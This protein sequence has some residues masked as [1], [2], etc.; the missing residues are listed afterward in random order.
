MANPLPVLNRVLDECLRRVVTS[1][2]ERSPADWISR[3]ADLADLK[4]HI[5]VELCRRG[6]LLEREDRI[7]LLFRRTTYPTVDGEPERRVIERIEAA[8][9]GDPRDVD[10]RTAVLIA[11]AD[12]GRLLKPVFGKTWVNER[13]ARIERIVKDDLVGNATRAAIA[14]FEAAM[15]AGAI[16]AVA[17]AA[18]A[19]SN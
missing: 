17:T 4:G 13:R 3:F 18:I 6:I 11:L 7:L 5:A 12:G 1:S 8:V 14:A 19:A 10:E 2:K 9:D 15:V 16:G